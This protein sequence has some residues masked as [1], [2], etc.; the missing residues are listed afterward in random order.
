MI[1][2]PLDAHMSFIPAHKDNTRVIV[3]IRKC[4]RNISVTTIRECFMV[5]PHTHSTHQCFTLIQMWAFMICG[6]YKHLRSPHKK[7]NS[8]LWLFIRNNLYKLIKPSN[9]P[10]INTRIMK[11]FWKCV[12]KNIYLIYANIIWAKNRYVYLLRVSIIINQR[13]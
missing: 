5:S 4:A 13:D 3:I 9:W 7:I 2:D 11:C 6:A 10:F 8:L 12:E 1:W